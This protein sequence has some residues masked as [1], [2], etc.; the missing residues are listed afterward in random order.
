MPQ[1]PSPFCPCLSSDSLCPQLWED[2]QLAESPRRRLAPADA[3]RPGPSAWLSAPGPGPGCRTPPVRK[4]GPGLGT[5]GSEAAGEAAAGRPP[6]A[7]SSYPD[8]PPG[9]PDAGQACVR[10][11]Q[12]SRV[13]D[14]QA[15]AGLW[16]SGPAGRRLP[17]SRRPWRTA[18]GWRDAETFPPLPARASR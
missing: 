2:R 4:P 13:A 7:A 17:F 11:V 9:K 5:P 16:V 10:F 6:S 14:G 12:P 8:R 15:G 1:V 3:L 18:H